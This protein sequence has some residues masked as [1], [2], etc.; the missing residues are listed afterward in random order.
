MGYYRSKI[1]Q[2]RIIIIDQI[3]CLKARGPREHEYPI[4]LKL[5]AAKKFVTAMSVMGKS[6][7][8][9]GTIISG[10]LLEMAARAIKVLRADGTIG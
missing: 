7:D 9:V 8:T 6:S 3:V 2:G 4:F 1:K 10:G 5:V